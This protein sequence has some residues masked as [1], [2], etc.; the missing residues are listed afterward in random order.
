MRYRGDLWG[1]LVSTYENV[2]EMIATWK[3]GQKFE[4]FRTYDSSML[5]KKMHK[6]RNP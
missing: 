5:F 2:R 1:N 3:L 4:P 6:N